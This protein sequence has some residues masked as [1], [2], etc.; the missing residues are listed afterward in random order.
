MADLLKFLIGFAMVAIGL[1]IWFSAPV[2]GPEYVWPF[3]WAI[4]GIAFIFIGLVFVFNSAERIGV[5]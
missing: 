5:W 2:S 1:G 4:P 3:A